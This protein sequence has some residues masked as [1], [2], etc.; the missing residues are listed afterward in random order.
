MVA[1]KKD[2]RYTEGAHSTHLTGTRRALFDQKKTTETEAKNKKVM[3]VAKI[4]NCGEK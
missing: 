2:Y 4:M 1:K 3:A